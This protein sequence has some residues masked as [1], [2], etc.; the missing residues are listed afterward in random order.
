MVLMVVAR[1]EGCTVAVESGVVDMMDAVMV[2]VL[3]AA[4]IADGGSVFFLPFGG[5]GVGGEALATELSEGRGKS[6][7]TTSDRLSRHTKSAVCEVFMSKRSERCGEGDPNCGVQHIA[8]DV[9]T[10]STE[11]NLQVK[12][13]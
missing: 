2:T 13:G 9:R 4:G 6:P 7:R 1:L 3:L 11:E 5:L 10:A 12:Y 8:V